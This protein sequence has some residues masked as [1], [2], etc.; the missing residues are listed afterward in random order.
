MLPKT[1]RI[2]VA[3]LVS[4]AWSI[5]LSTACS[6]ECDPGWEI[7]NHECVRTAA[8][9]TGEDAGAPGDGAAADG[10]QPDAG[11]DGG[12]AGSQCTESQFGA[13]CQQ[14]LQTGECT[15][16]TDYCAGYPG[17]PGI[18]TRSGC[19]ENPSVCPS[20]WNC[21]DLSVYSPELP[22]ICVSG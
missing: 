14:S 16:D 8:A 3:A 4:G 18:C 1:A 11:G 20:G 15:C 7:R 6:D 22:S 21:T 5:T 2:V 9:A 19:L 13:T 12:D 17:S 10:I